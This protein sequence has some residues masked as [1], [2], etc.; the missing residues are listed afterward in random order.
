[1]DRACFVLDGVK[2]VSGR[3]GQAP[4]RAAGRWGSF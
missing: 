1:V 4:N 2:R 3:S